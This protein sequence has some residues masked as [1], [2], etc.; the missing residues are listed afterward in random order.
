MSWKSKSQSHQHQRHLWTIRINEKSWPDSPPWIIQILPVR[1]GGKV[2]FS[3]QTKLSKP[4]RKVIMSRIYHLVG[5]SLV[6]HEKKTQIKLTQFTQYITPPF[7]NYPNIDWSR[8]SVHAISSLRVRSTYGLLLSYCP[9]STADRVLGVARQG[10]DHIP[11][12]YV[13]YR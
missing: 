12:V 5:L 3:I 10:E 7:S 13:Y 8:I 6:H 4:V 1:I 9:M 11:V 2:I